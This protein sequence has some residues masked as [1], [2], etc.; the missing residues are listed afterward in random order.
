MRRTALALLMG[1]L[2]LA[3]WSVGQGPA[4]AEDPP[5][6]PEAREATAEEAAAAVADLEAAAKKKKAA[7]ALALLAKA[8]ALRHK[9]LEKPLQRLLRHAEAAVALKAAELLETRSSPEGAKALWAASWG[10]AVNEKRPA[11][12]AKALRALGAAGLVLDK[13]Q[14]DEVER[15]WR[16]IQ[17][18]PNRTQAPLLV[19]VATYVE[20][21]KDKRF[22]R[23]LAEA[24]DEPVSGDANSPTNPPASW[25]EEKWN[26]WNESKAAVHT[27]LR[28][29]TGQ[30]FRTTEQARAWIEEHAKEGFSW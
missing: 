28:A 25:W 15:L 4:L 26:L 24:L 17:G 7:E 3:A 5:R 29:L 6:P 12:R 30:D 21:A 27:A 8:E 2:G 10:Q 18:N 23:Q 19:D 11:V 16:S 13:R 14:G 9:D 1:P 22:A 20:R